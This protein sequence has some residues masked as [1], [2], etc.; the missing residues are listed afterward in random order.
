MKKTCSFLIAAL[1]AFAALVVLTPPASA[2]VTPTKLVTVTNL[3]AT[4]ATG[5]ISN[6]TSYV[7]ISPGQG[8]AFSAKFAVSS[9]TTA[10]PVLLYP[11][12]DGTNYASTAWQFFVPVNGGT[13]QI[14]TT[15]FSPAALAGYKS[16]K[17]GALTNANAGTLTNQGIVVGNWW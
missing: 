10:A 1:L 8:L 2:Q 3:P 4:V 15:N 12:V 5:A 11:S 7:D 13:P 16:I 9:G 14:G 17:V 6:S